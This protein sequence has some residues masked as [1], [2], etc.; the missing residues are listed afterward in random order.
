MV[1]QAP[2]PLV[3]GNPNH[4]PSEEASSSAHIYMFNGIDS[5]TC[6]TMYDTP[7]KPDKEKVTNGTTSDPPPA[8]ITPQSGSLQ[9]EKPTF[10]SILHP[11]KSTIG[12]STFNPSSRVAQNYNIVEDLAQAPCAM[13]ILKVLQ[14]FPSQRRTLLAAIG[15]IDSESSNN[16]M[17]NL[18]N[19]KS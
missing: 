12:K 19:F 11:P 17:F 3:R 1:A 16:T 15:V 8:T 2:A 7:T 10:D 6:T 13:S 4:S 9:I 14:H 18:G 5:T